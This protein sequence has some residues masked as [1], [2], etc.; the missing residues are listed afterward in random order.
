MKLCPGSKPFFR[1]SS[2]Y[3][4]YV[5]NE[6][7]NVA[8]IGR[9]VYELGL[10]QTVQIGCSRTAQSGR[11]VPTNSGAPCYRVLY[12]REGTSYEFNGQG[13]YRGGA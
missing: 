6:N 1:I 2:H 10:H 4:F 3:R 8:V 11:L 7:L 9:F 12:E 5:N 13:P